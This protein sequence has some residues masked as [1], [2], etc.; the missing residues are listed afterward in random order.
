MV[1]YPNGHN[2]PGVRWVIHHKPVGQAAQQITAIPLLNVIRASPSNVHP[3]D[4]TWLSKSKAICPK[5]SA[6]QL[7]VANVQKLR[8]SYG[9]IC[10]AP[11]VLTPASHHYLSGQYDTS[12]QFVGCGLLEQHLYDWKEYIG[13]STVIAPIDKGRHGFSAICPRGWQNRM[14]N[15]HI[16]RAGIKFGLPLDYEARSEKCS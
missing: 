13:E 14:F 15:L 7:H 1:I 5:K 9:K 4:S 12:G 11:L 3:T 8:D 6:L 10:R 2:T 16:V